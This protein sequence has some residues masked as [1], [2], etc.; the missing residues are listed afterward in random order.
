MTGCVIALG[1]N[2]GDPAGAIKSAL[3]VISEHSD[4]SV[5]Q[6]SRLVESFAMT[7]DGIDKSKPNYLNSVAKL[8]TTLS[9]HEL[10]AFLNSVEAGFGR[11]RQ[12]RWASRTLDID[13]ITFG[14]EQI[15][16]DELVI[17]HP[18]AHQRGFVLIPWLDMDPAAELPG[19]GRVSELAKGMTNEVWFHEAD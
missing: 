3:A 10:L 17:P 8:E 11:V 14:D 1:G 2:L 13:I 6:S 4:I 5:L 9:P 18:R 19:K 15:Q 7:T 12:E 16:T